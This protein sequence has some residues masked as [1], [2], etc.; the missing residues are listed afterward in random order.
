VT[1]I[2][3]PALAQQ[4]QQV[5]A[6]AVLLQRLRQPLELRVVD[7]AGAPGDLLGAGDLQ[8]LAVFQRGDEL[9]GLQQAV[10]RAGVQPGVAALHDLHR[11]LALLQVGLVDGG[12]LQLAARAGLH[13]L[14]MS[15]TWLS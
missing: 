14:A 11:Q 9:A 4:L 8:A 13:D 2:G 3:H 10:V 6:V 5:L 12:D 15:T 1:F 7:E